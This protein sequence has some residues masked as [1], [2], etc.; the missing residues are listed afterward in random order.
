MFG[1]YG[2]FLVGWLKMFATFRTFGNYSIFW[3]CLLKMFVFDKFRLEFKILA[4]AN[5]NY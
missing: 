3:G 2:I 4:A 1:F 5:A